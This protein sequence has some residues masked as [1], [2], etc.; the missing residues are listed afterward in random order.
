MT[1]DDNRLIEQFFAEA[2]RQ[3][4]ADDGFSQRVMQQL[5]QQERR[6]A[7]QQVTFLSS[8]SFSRLW[9]L[10]CVALATVLF[11]TF[12]GWELLQVQL[13]V[14]VRT[15]SANMQG[16]NPLLWLTALLGLIGI[17]VYELAQKVNRMVF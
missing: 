12:H 9:T 16:Q 8:R 3:S 15:A 6:Q 5:E 17:A 10:G 2:S 7:S 13:E 11:V 4:V 1:E 14:M